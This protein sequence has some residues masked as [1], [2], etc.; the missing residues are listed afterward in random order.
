LLRTP[1]ATRDIRECVA[2]GRIFISGQGRRQ[3]GAQA[4]IGQQFGP[5]Q[6]HV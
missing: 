1:A 5:F 6:M 4:Q 3:C 2:A